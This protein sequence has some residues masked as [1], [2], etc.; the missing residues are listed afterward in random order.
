MTEFRPRIRNSKTI[1][2]DTLATRLS[3][4]SLVT[5]SIARMVLEDLTDEVSTGLREGNA[6]VLPGVG[7]FG[8]SLALLAVYWTR[9]QVLSGRILPPTRWTRS[10]GSEQ[11]SIS[12]PLLSIR[13]EDRPARRA[14]AQPAHDLAP[15]RRHRRA[16]L[17]AVECLDELPGQSRGVTYD[18]IL[19]LKPCKECRLK[20]GQ[21][22]PITRSSTLTPQRLRTNGSAILHRGV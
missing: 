1:G 22:V 8:V 5:R 10:R 11:S 15:I 4:G 17:R 14:R 20:R 3:R 12:R 6:V 19:L 18:V 21:R 7:R 13:P 2:L 9:G 16:T